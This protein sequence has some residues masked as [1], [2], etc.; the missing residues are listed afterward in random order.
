M[1]RVIELNRNQVNELFETLSAVKVSSR[2]GLHSLRIA[3]DNGKEDTV[4]FKVNNTAWSP[5][6]GT[7]DPQCRKAARARVEWAQVQAEHSGE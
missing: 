2:T 1:D 5:S 3:V 6:M 4:S 7:L